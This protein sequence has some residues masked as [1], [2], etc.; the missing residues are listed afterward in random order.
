MVVAK[1]AKKKT[2]QA[3]SKVSVWLFWADMVDSVEED[4]RHIQM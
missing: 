3:L 1:L 4:S 2:Q